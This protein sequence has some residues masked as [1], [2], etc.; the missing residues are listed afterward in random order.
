MTS[1]Q[2]TLLAKQLADFESKMIIFLFNSSAYINEVSP[3]N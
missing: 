2:V 3:R 1:S